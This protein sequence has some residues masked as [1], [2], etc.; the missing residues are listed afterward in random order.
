MGRNCRC[1]AIACMVMKSAQDQYCPPPKLTRVD[2]VHG[3][4]DTL[5]GIQIG[6]EGIQNLIAV[7]RECCRK[8]LL[9]SNGQV[10]EWWWWSATKWKMETKK[11]TQQQVVSVGTMD[12][13]TNGQKEL[14]ITPHDHINK[15]TSPP[16]LQRRHPIPT[17]AIE[18]ASRR[19]RVP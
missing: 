6:N 16:W 1:T 9:D 14:R 12:T 8:C 4:L 15:N 3:V 19:R 11:K 7:A 17:W 2:F 5:I 13:R 18:L 10:L